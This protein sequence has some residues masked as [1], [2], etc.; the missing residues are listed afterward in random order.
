MACNCK[1][2]AEKAGKYSDNQEKGVEE[3][4]GSQRLVVILMR[5]I[6]TI[7]ATGV[8]IVILPFM[9]L[10]ILICMIVGKEI[11]FNLGKILNFNAKRK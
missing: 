10:Y 4:N 6:L 5:I 2:T 11:R 7:L 3:I 1:K 9:I 8:I